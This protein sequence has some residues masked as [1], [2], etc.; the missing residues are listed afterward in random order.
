MKKPLLA[1][2]A[3]AMFSHIAGSAFA[4][5]LPLLAAPVPV[6]SWTS[7][8]LGAHVGGGWAH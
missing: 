1:G 4:A 6:F 3:L 2:A 5:D 8:F 7:C